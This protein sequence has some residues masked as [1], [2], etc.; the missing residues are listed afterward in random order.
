MS[1]FR[2]LALIVSAVALTVAAGIPFPASIPLPVDFAPEGIA[3]GPRNTFYAGSLTT[4]DIFRGSLRTG[5]GAIFV[6]A[7]PGRSATGMKVEPSA[8]RLWVA[9]G[10]T[11]H[12]YVYSTRNG[13]TIKDLVLNSSGNSLINDVMVT[14]HAAYFT[15]TFN[16]VIYKI[17][18]GK[19]GRI[20][21]PK[22]IPLTGPAAVM[23]AFPNLNGIAA[24]SNGKVLILGH[25]SRAELYLVNPRTGSSRTITVTGGALTPGTPD[26]ILLDGRI[27]W[28]VEN[29]ANR[30]VKIKLSPDLTRGRI[31]ATVTSKL[32][33][34]PTAVAKSGDRLALVNARFD[35]GFPPPF[36]PGAPKGTDFDV[37][38]IRKPDQPSG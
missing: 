21:A 15:D 31:T 30:L 14:N 6:D 32:F 35:L 10:P 37:V 7:P 4:G 2:K 12:A 29:F 3:S 27:L 28:V 13:K 23:G 5:K 34:V 16:P 1:Y 9:G 36:G 17:P 33:R 25:S 19:H 20:G 8:K 38:Q 24:P 22:T 11:G 26:G 18:I